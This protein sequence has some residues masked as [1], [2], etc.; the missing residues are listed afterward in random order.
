MAWRVSSRRSRPERH[1]RLRGTDNRPTRGKVLLGVG[2]G[3]FIGG[4]VSQE[5]H[6]RGALVHGFGR[7]KSYPEALDGIQFTNA[8]FSDRASLARAIEGAEYVFHL[9]ASGTPE[10][11]NRDPVADLE[12]GVSGTLHLL[13]ICRAAGVRKVV[14]VSSGGDRVRCSRK[15]PDR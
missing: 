3:G 7:R 12:A 9:L 4:H 2:A 11:S 13:A 1:N 8:E 15:R 10:S 5:L 6:R 14:F